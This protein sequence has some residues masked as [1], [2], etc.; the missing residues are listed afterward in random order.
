[1]L[2]CR[3]TAADTAP[4]QVSNARM[5]TSASK[6]LGDLVELEAGPSWLQARRIPVTE[7]AQKVRLD[8]CACEELLVHAG[9]VEARHRPAIEPQRARRHDEVS[10]L[11]RAVA[12]RDDLRLL[13]LFRET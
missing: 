7:I 9:I 11:Q 5:F 13:G 12:Q 6:D 1:M 10:A 2:A 4:R 3:R 8:V